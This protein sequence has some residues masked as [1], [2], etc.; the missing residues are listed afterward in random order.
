MDADG[1]DVLSFTDAQ[2]T[3][4]D[5]FTRVASELANG[6]VRR[7]PYKVRDAMEEYLRWCAKRRKSVDGTRYSINAHILPVLGDVELSKLTK[8][9]VERWHEQL[10]ESPARLRTRPGGQQN[11]RKRNSGSETKRGRK[12]TANRILTTLKAALNY[13]YT[14]GRV[15][16]N[17]AWRRVQPFREVEVARARYLTDD[18]ALRLV[19][20]CTEPFRSLVVGALM[21]GARYSELAAI[22]AAD[23]DPRA[24]TVHIRQSKSGKSRHVVLSDEGRTFLD[25]TTVG[26]AAQDTV[27]VKATGN[28]WRRSDQR[29]PLRQAYDAARIKPAVGFHVLRHSYASRLVM[30]GVPL[31]VIAAQLGHRD[32]RMV[33]RHYGH[34]SPGYVASTVREAF[35]SM[36]IVDESNVTPLRR[37]AAHPNR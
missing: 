35:G 4:R 26:K 1:A 21:T 7:G 9:R 16:G 29:R 18:E 24:G 14:E 23:F 31:A 8:H 2:A 34:L 13:A 15:A 28:S 11:Y 12:S 22:R 30:R 3:A 37:E 5:W 27:F 36:G 6:D 19:N 33:E 10:A 17:D 20:A 25:G 32:T